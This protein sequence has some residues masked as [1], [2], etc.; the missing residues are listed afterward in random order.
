MTQARESVDLTFNFEEVD[1]DTVDHVPTIAQPEFILNLSG[2]GRGCATGSP[3]RA[4][5]PSTGSCAPEAG[6]ARL[7]N[8][9]ASEARLES[10]QCMRNPLVIG[11]YVS[12]TRSV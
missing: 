10:F 8:G 9:E 2:C 5:T 6:E 1:T 12:I 3:P 4:I 7:A 11:S